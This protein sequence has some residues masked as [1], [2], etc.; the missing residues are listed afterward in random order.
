MDIAKT[1]SKSKVMIQERAAYYEIRIYYL[2]CIHNMCIST[3]KGGN[4]PSS[5]PRYN[6]IASASIEYQYAYDL[7]IEQLMLSVV[8]LILNIGMDSHD[9]SIPV[10]REEINKTIKEYT[11]DDLL[12][13]IPN[14]EKYEFLSDLVLLDVIKH[15]DSIQ[16]PQPLFLNNYSNKLNNKCSTYESIKNTF[17]ECIYKGSR[18]KISLIKQNPSCELP[19]NYGTIYTLENLK[20]IDQSP[21]QELILTI[22]KLVAAIDAQLKIYIDGI[23]NEI[24]HLLTLHDI[25]ELMSEL[26]DNDKSALLYDIKKLEIV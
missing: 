25:D 5:L 19:E 15:S 4:R 7:P 26:T 9:A 6:S 20:P 21:I 11:L 8:E 13:N 12:S 24:N 16:I 14:E 3:L 10:F 23:R 18:Q 1:H 22:L 17:F 2:N